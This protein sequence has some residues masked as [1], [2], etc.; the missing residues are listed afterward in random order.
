ME[1]NVL[2]DFQ[3]VQT[4]LELSIIRGARAVVAI[5]M[6]CQTITVAQGW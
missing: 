6:F 5:Y 4:D 3:A 2:H 1:V